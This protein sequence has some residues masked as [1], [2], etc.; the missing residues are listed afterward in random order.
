[1]F[2]VLGGLERLHAFAVLDW[3]C[4]PRLF[5]STRSTHSSVPAQTILLRDATHAQ[6]P[7]RSVPIN[8]HLF[9]WVQCEVEKQMFSFLP[10]KRRQSETEII[11]MDHSSFVSLLIAA[12]GCNN[13]ARPEKDQVS[14]VWGK[15]WWLEIDWIEPENCSRVSQARRG[16]SGCVTAAHSEVSQARSFMNSQRVRIVAVPFYF[17][18]SPH[19][20]SI[21]GFL[22]AAMSA[23]TQN[24]VR[25]IQLPATRGN[26]SIF[27]LVREPQKN[28]M[29]RGD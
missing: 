25:L 2:A 8:K 24:Y 18:N 6:S 22:F 23:T 29:L 4:Q 13:I 10:T 26:F 28:S 19:Q 27:L 11:E 16:W 20:Y 9:Y 17:P 14:S 21:T 1:M 7:H 15:W 5:L 3:L 12:N